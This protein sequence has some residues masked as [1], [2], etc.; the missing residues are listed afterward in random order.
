MSGPEHVTARM[1]RL[2]V[3]DADEAIDRLDEVLERL[4]L[5]IVETREHVVDFDEAFVRVIERHRSSADDRAGRRCR[6]P[7]VDAGRRT[8]T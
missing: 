1:W 2:V 3:D 8:A 4:Q 5:P 7:D 6:R